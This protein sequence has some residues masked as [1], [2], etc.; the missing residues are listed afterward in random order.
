VA[1][2][3]EEFHYRASAPASGPEVLAVDG[4]VSSIPL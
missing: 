2:L 3:I 1:S 4:V